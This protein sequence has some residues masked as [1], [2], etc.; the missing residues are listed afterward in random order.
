GDQVA[1]LLK[2]SGPGMEDCEWVD[3]IPEPNVMWPCQPCNNCR[4]VSRGCVPSHSMDAG[5]S[6]Y[7]RTGGLE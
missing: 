6:I 5:A 1:W 3:G 7:P 4:L 2:T